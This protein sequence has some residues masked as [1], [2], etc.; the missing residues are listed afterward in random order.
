MKLKFD[1][2]GSS[3]NVKSV[4]SFVKISKMGKK[5]RWR[6]NDRHTNTQSQSQH[7]DFVV[8]LRWKVAQRVSALNQRD[9]L[10][11]TGDKNNGHKQF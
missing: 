9:N 4:T 2:G 6:Q 7:G 8:P 5:M 10:S 3:R 11:F 1:V